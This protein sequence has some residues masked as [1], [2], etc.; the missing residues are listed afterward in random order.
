MAR[1]LAALS[2]IEIVMQLTLKPDV[3]AG[4]TGRGAHNDRPVEVGHRR[5][6][7]IHCKGR[8]FRIQTLVC[9]EDIINTAVTAS[10]D[11][12]RRFH[13]LGDPWLDNADRIRSN[14]G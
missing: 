1:I 5:I 11:S 3:A 7:L 14:R 8:G 12:F 6:G 4:S 13:G 2:I 9:A 10:G